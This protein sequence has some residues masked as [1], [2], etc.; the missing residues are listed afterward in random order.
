MN[1]YQKW[2]RGLT[3]VGGL[4]AVK[5]VVVLGLAFVGVVPIPLRLLLPLSVAWLLGAGLVLLLARSVSQRG[6]AGRRSLSVPD[7]SGPQSRRQQPERSAD[8]A[9]HHSR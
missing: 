9:L 5:V 7:G 4:L 6:E 2:G 3:L 1:R 8:V